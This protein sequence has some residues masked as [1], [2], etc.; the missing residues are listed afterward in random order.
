MIGSR[1]KD[2]DQHSI[3]GLPFWLIPHNQRMP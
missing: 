3:Q 1:E 2:H